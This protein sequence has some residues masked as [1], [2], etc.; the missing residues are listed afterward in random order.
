M[1]SCAAV[2]KGVLQKLARKK[3]IDKDVM[4]T[5]LKRCLKTS[6]LIFLGIGQMAGAGMYI[7]TG[8][9]AKNH[10]GPATFISYII[11]GL[12]SFLSAMC[13]AEFAARVPRAGS[14]YSYAYVTVGE[15]I[16]FIIGWNILLE[17]CIGGAST[18]R[19]WGGSLDSLIGNAIS[20]W[21]IQH[22]SFQPSPSWLAKYPDLVAPLFLIVLCIAVALGAKISLNINMGVAILNIIFTALISVLG[23]YYGKPENLTGVPFAPHGASGIFVGA[24][25]CVYAYVGI[26]GIAVA[27]EEA[28]S[29][30]TS[31]PKANTVALLVVTAMYIAMSLALV[32]VA[33]Y[34]TLSVTAPFAEAFERLGYNWIK[35]LVIVGTLTAITCTTLGHTFSAPRTM[36]AMAGDGVIF[37]F[38]SYVNSCTQTP[39][40][41]ILIFLV[42]AGVLTVLFDLEE[43]ANMSSMGT[44]VTFFS[45]S[46]CIIVLRY[47]PRSQE[48]TDMTQLVENVAGERQNGESN[49]YEIWNNSGQ[50]KPRYKNLPILKDMPP[51][52]AVVIAT[53]SMSA[54]MLVLGAVVIPGAKWLMSATWWS[55]LLTLLSSLWIMVSFSVLLLHE[56]DSQISTYKVPL[57]PLLPSISMLMNMGLL[58]SLQK[59]VWIRL[60]I[61]MVAGG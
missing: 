10:A 40:V 28:E 61:W 7:M 31:I 11:A 43:L 5:P 41:A 57:V 18:A 3:P 35:I 58:L 20:N 26:D 22:A 30:N 46:A 55:I 39:L 27:G 12:V 56:Q 6:H 37:K 34:W 54:A 33:P 32:L 59:A 53:G 8:V 47:Q 29:P 52:R 25:M 4:E 36:Y 44:I 15:F 42:I 9:V 45:V 51:G 60:G 2:T 14:S 24:S 49:T 48:S 50:L 38:I 13:Y 19:A 17:H 16:A 23:Y 21:T 1:S